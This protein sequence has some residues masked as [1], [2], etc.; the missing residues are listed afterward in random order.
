MKQVTLNAEEVRHDLA[1]ALD[2]CRSVQIAILPRHEVC[3]FRIQGAADKAV[4]G[5]MR[6]LGKL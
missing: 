2:L 4:D 1:A 6:I 5:L 3:P